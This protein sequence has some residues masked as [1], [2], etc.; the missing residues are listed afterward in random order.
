MS[1]FIPALAG[2][3]A[4]DK[5]NLVRKL[6]EFFEDTTRMNVNEV[7]SA[8]MSLNCLGECIG[9]EDDIVLNHLKK[10]LV[11]RMVALTE[12]ENTASN[13]KSLQ[14]CALLGIKNEYDLRAKANLLAYATELNKK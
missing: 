5:E 13:E 11:Q 14:F 12:K 10:A 1:K 8:Y 9:A 6:H 7:T 2:L 3:Q 4:A